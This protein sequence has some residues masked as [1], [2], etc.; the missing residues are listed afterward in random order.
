ELMTATVTT[1]TAPIRATMISVP[2][3][4]LGLLCFVRPSSL[5][6]LGLQ[7]CQLPVGLLELLAQNLDH[8]GGVDLRFIRIHG[9][10]LLWGSMGGSASDPG[11]GSESTSTRSLRTSVWTCGESGP[12]ASSEMPCPRRQRD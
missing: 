11:E 1:L 8:D 6:E 12:A 5:H 4:S 7:Q 9:K 3:R 2:M 10:L